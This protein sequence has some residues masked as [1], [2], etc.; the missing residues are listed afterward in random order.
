MTYICRFPVWPNS[1]VIYS[2]SYGI[3]A[4]SLCYFANAI[5]QIFNFPADG[6]ILPEFMLFN[7]HKLK[8]K[9]HTF[10]SR[11]GLLVISRNK[12]LPL[13]RSR[14]YTAKRKREQSG[15]IDKCT[16]PTRHNPTIPIRNHRTRR[17]WVHHTSR[18][19]RTVIVHLSPRTGVK[20]TFA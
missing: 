20:P 19:P 18:Q 5:C 9:F 3:P 2:L 17:P 1:T 15:V 7:T 6:S 10:V 11:L 16:T 14:W 8:C 4:Y 13:C 12:R